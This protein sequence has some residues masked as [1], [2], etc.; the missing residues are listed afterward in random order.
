LAF[1]FEDVN[2]LKR[3]M[4]PEK[5]ANSKRRKPE[6]ILSTEIIESI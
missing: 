1:L 5:T 4:K 2:A 3:Q 6:S